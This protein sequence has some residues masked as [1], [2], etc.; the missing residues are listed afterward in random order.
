MIKFLAYLYDEV[1]G[2]VVH[3]VWGDVIIDCEY[4]L[5]HLGCTYDNWWCSIMS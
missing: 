2:V 5:Y 3:R 1:L 4:L